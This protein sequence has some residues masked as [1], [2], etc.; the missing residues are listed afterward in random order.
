MRRSIEGD[1]YQRAAFFSKWLAEGAAF[2][3]GRRLSG[4]RLSEGGI[5]KRKYGIGFLLLP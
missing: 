4:R 5:H 2:N 3:R 1:V